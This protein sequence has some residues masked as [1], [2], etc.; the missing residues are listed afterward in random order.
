MIYANAADGDRIE[1]LAVQAGLSEREPLKENFLRI[2]PL[3]VDPRINV[4]VSLRR[5]AGPAR[6]DHVA[7]RRLSSLGNRN[8]VIPSRRRLVA[9]SAK[10]AEDL[11]YKGLA[12][13]WHWVDATRTSMDSLTSCRPESRDGGVSI[14]NVLPLVRQ[15]QSFL[16]VGRPVAARFAPEQTEQSHSIANRQRRSAPNFCPA[17]LATD[18]SESVESRPINRKRCGREK[19][20]ALGTPPFA[21]RAAVDVLRIRLACVLALSH[22]VV[23]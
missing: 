1:R 12:F 20:P 14:S 9:V 8:N 13:G 18:V 15:A 21:V 2:D 6:R 10:S 23:L 3:R 19:R 16:C 17:A 7:G 22:G 5:V 4:P 11:K